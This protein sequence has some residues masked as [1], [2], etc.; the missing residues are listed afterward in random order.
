MEGHIVIDVIGKRE[1]AS[2]KP[3][4]ELKDGPRVG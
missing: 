4:T 2:V 3:G 1:I